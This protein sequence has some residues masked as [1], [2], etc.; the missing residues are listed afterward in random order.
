MMCTHA[1]SG[2]YIRTYVYFVLWSVCTACT[3]VLCIYVCVCIHSC[4]SMYVCFS[5]ILL[6]VVCREGRV[7]EHLLCHSIIGRNPLKELIM[8]V[9][10]AATFISPLLEVSQRALHFTAV[11]V[12]QRNTHTYIRTHAHTH[13]HTRA[14]RMS[15][16]VTSYV[17]LSPSLLLCRSPAAAL[18]HRKRRLL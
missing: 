9:D 18:S 3:D 17:H 15:C 6:C 1:V 7:Q 2:Y 10:M 5:S 16:N 12:S 14:I 4:V 13:A 8:T 11:L